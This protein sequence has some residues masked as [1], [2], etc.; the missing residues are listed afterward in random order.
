MDTKDVGRGT[1]LALFG[2]LWFV[3]AVAILF[4]VSPLTPLGWVFVV[5]GAPVVIGIWALLEGLWT[6]LLSRFERSSLGRRLDKRAAGRPVS[7]FRVLFG[8]MLALG[9]LMLVFA[10]ASGGV[11]LLDYP[12]FWQRH[13]RPR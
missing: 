12:E 4:V 6:E 7:A 5:L 10:L 1:W 8:V 3:G 9:F 11:S 2:V 13:F